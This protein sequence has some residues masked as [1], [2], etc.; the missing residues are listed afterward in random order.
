MNAIKTILSASLMIAGVGGAM[1]TFAAEVS[2]TFAV[3][4]NEANAKVN[5]GDFDGALARYAEV[6]QFAPESADLSYNMAV[7]RYRKGEV[8]AAEPLFQAAAASENDS[9]AAKAR[10]NLGN[11]SYTSGLELAE[12]DRPAAIEKLESAIENYRSSLTVDPNNADARANIELAAQLIEKLRKEEKQQQEQQQ[13]NQQQNQDQQSNDQ[14]QKDN[15]QQNRENNQEEKQNEQQQN[16]E[17]KNQE[18]QKS[19]QQSNDEQSQDEQHND[20]QQ[21]QQNQDQEQQQDSQ[22]QSSQDEQQ[23][24]EQQSES[25]QKQ[26]QSQ[27][28]QSQQNEQQSKEQRQDSAQQQEQQSAPQDQPQESKS[29]QQQQSQQ[30]RSQQPQQ[31]QD[32]STAPEEMKEEQAKQPPQGELTAASEEEAKDGKEKQPIAAFDPTKDGEMTQEEADKMLQAIRDREMLR[33]YQRR[34]QEMRQYIPVDR[35]W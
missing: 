18:R 14:Q 35:D 22:S 34:Q 6:Q 7:A 21:Q 26:D 9:L 29:Q 4:V 10:Y 32:E 31:P 11:C 8:A 23:Q 17:H 30:R 19:E 27:Q 25:E 13:Q 12:K 16:Q 3:G 15:Q 33:R 20:Q 1:P 24:K 2:P 28:E 5:S